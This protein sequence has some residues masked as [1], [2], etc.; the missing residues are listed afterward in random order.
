V[1]ACEL[2]KQVGVEGEGPARSRKVSLTTMLVL[3]TLLLLA[4]PAPQDD[5]APSSEPRRP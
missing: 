1:G 4:V 3:A 2:E 5:D